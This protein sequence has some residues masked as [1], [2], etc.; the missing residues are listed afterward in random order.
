MIFSLCLFFLIVAFYFNWKYEVIAVHPFQGEGQHEL[1]VMTWN[2]HCPK[3]T[4]SIRQRKI[5]DLILKEDADFVLLNEYNQASCSLTDSLL[6]KRYPYQEEALSH[7]KCGN[8][9]YSKLELMHSGRFLIRHLRRF[10]P[11]LGGVV[12]PD[13]L[14]RKSPSAIVSTVCIGRDSVLIFGVHFPSNHYDGSTI[15][16]EL[17]NDTS[18][19]DRYKEAQEKRCFQAHWI[20]EAVL[21]SKHPVIVMGDMNDFNCSAPLDT[22]TSCGL[23]D[24]W[25]EGGNGYGCTY[26]NGWLRL[27]IDHI[28][29]S[30][31]LRLES[32]K[33]IETDLSD[34]NPVVAGF[35]IVKN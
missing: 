17:E 20:K 5:A 22:L 16:K 19:Y 18:S 35:S 6:R 9:Y 2:I 27:R 10:Q 30:K 8:I 25:W 14:K 24:S 26:H 3:D 23:K 11:A 32:V 12:Y 1:K 28:L 21:E 33:V 29:H 4:D 15:E 34:H 7:K 31:E 13:S